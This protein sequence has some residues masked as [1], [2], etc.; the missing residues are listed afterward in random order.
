M[1]ETLKQDA[2]I[3]KE[4]QLYSYCNSQTE[5]IAVEQM[6]K[7]HLKRETELEQT[8]WPITLKAKMDKM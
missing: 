2:Q 1:K 3:K 7:G 6:Q 4:R 5:L 8:P